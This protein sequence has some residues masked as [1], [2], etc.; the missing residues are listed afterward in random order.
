VSFSFRIKV[1]GITSEEVARTAI[2]AGANHLGLVFCASPR[3]VTLERAALLVACVP[4]SWVG[5]FADP[6]LE[7][8]AGAARELGL[9]AVQ[10]HGHETPAL[11]SAVRERTG[12]PVWKAI[13]PTEAEAAAFEAA[14]DA[15]LLDA[16]SGGTGRTLEWSTIGTRFPRARRIVPH[17]LAGG[18]SPSNV[19][20]AIREAGPDGVDASSR[21]EL[22]PGIKDLRLVSA[23]VREA[24]A[25]GEA[26]SESGLAE[27]AR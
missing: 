3:R 24:R 23:F 17:L 14:V 13:T 7:E 21:L 1:C 20:R 4:A 19:E 16:G 5:V 18:L 25:A 2:D 12:V 15:L 9:A 26:A 6:P 8:V 27:A 10:L 11:C 22:A